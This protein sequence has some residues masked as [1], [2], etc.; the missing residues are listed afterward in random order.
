MIVT[1]KDRRV[2]EIAD[3]RLPKQ[4]PANLAFAA[5]RRIR[6]LIVAKV[7]EDLRIPTGNRLEALRGDRAGQHSIRINDQWQLC[8]RWVEDGAHDVELVD[9]Q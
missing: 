9:Y 7:L 2:L 3:G 1:V 5:E 8:F 4:F 6:A